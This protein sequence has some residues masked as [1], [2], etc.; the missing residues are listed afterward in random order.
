MSPRKPSQEPIR[1]EKRADGEWF[2]LP[3]SGCS[4]PIPRWPHGTPSPAE[5]ARWRRLWRLPIAVWW[6]EQQIDPDLIGRYVRLAYSK[7]HLGSISRIENDLGLTPA[8]MMR[9]RLVVE[10]PEEPKWQP[11]GRYDHVRVEEE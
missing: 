5:A 7:P 3:S 4:R 11:R 8:G 2:V 9:L 10:G 6:W 1:R